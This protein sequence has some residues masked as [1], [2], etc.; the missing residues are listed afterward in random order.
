MTS[1]FLV[2]DT[3]LDRMVYRAK[4]GDHVFVV[5]FVDVGDHIANKPVVFRY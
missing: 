1:D 4:L 2:Q 5:F 3:E